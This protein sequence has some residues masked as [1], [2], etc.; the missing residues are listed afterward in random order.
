MSAGER[1]MASLA[2]AG[3]CGAVR[4]VADSRPAAVE[5]QRGLRVRVLRGRLFSQEK[6]MVAPAP[7]SPRNGHRPEFLLFGARHPSLGFGQPEKSVLQLS[8]LRRLDFSGPPVQT[9]V[10]LR[11][12]A[13]RRLVRRDPVLP[14]HKHGV[15]VL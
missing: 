15:L 11:F 8:R 12:A 2:A 14:H 1:K 4:R 9:A 7:G 6:F 5:F 13:R 10:V 3:I